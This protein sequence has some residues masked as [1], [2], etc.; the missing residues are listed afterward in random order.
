[1]TCESF[2]DC[3]ERRKYWDLTYSDKTTLEKRSVNEM[4]D[5]L[6]DKLLDAVK[7]RLVADVPAGF[8]LSGG[9]DSAA[10]CGMAVAIIEEECAKNNIDPVKVKARMK[11]FCVGFEKGTEF[12]E[13][14]KYFRIRILDLRRLQTE[15]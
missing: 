13:A 1:M 15:H 9:I 4:I 5:D 2:D 10:I 12:D 6:R 11:C 7:S 3:L 8:Y 14:R